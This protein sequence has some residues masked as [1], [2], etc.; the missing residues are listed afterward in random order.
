[1]SLALRHTAHPFAAPAPL[2]GMR[3]VRISDARFMA[4]LQRKPEP[5]VQQRYAEGH[6]AYVALVEG[7]PAAWGW[8]ATRTATIG[9]LSTSFN[10]PARTRYLWNFV[11]AAEHRGKG[12]YPRLL[13]AIVQAESVEAERFWIIYAPENHASASGI[14]KAGFS[15]VATLSFDAMGVP[16]V[17]AAE[18]AAGRAAADLLGVP[19]SAGSLSQCWRCARSQNAQPFREACKKM[20]VAS[21]GPTATEGLK[22]H[23]LQVDYEPSHPKM[24]ILVKEFS[25]QIHALRQAKSPQQ[26]EA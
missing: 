13:D 1:M 22:H 6:R 21:I 12:I 14:H 7:E 8:V 26:P 5:A 16:A 2:A 24:G 11:T 25:E 15:T 17:A 23:E 3:V 4:Q 10:I 9:E 20:V 19:Q 18:R